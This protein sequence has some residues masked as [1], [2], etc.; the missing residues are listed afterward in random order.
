MENQ[1]GFKI[2]GIRTE[3]FAT[4]EENF[5]EKKKS[6]ALEAKKHLDHYLGLFELVLLATAKY[7]YR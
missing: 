6:E 7:K 2:I 4:I 5:V 1:I 3:Q